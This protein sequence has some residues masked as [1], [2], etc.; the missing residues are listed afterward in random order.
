MQM[1]INVLSSLITNV[2][3]LA[4][5]NGEFWSWEGTDSVGKL[6]TGVQSHFLSMDL[7]DKTLF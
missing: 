1:E 5:V 7:G 2:L 3:T 6:A 4:S